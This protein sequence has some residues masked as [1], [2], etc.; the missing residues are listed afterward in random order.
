MVSPFMENG[1][2]P[3]YLPKTE[4]AYRYLLISFRGLQAQ[5]LADSRHA[6]DSNS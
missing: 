3:A 2:L 1:S 4:D 5:D 6:V